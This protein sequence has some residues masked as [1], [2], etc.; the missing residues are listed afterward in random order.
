[1]KWIN[2]IG[3]GVFLAS[4]VLTLIPIV[5]FKVWH[6]VRR[7]RA[8]LQDRQ[9][10]HVPGQ[11]LLQ[12]IEKEQQEINYAVDLMIIALPLMFLIWATQRIDW[13]R[14]HFATNEGIYTA[15]WFL[16]M[17]YGLWH[18]KR[19]YLIREQARDGL[20]AERVTGM[21]LNRLVAQ[22]CTVM[23]DIPAD[24]FNLDHVVIAPGGVYAIET[25]SFRKPRHDAEP[26][27]PATVRW[28]GESL[29][30]PDFQTKA[31]IEQAR[32]QAQW[33]ANFL[34]E[35]VATDV[36][37]R[38]CV[39]LPGWFIDKSDA[40]KKSDVFVFTPMGRGC[41]YFSYGEGVL[42]PEQRALIAKALA[43]RYPLIDN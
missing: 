27:K 30:F 11:Q 9:A 26:G 20:V 28:A 17:L 23:H 40:A 34:R 19:H 10:G 37:V 43:L 21:Q 7:R 42:A 18:Y 14:V 38:P 3:H 36:A 41:E 8:P 6:T 15:C 22:G 16:L 25:K 31:P 29:V 39:A 1:M 13:S 32:R 2:F 35:A 12:R 24:G 5:G 4:M 33:L